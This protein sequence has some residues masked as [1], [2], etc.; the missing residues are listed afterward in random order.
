MADESFLKNFG[1]GGFAGLSGNVG[2]ALTL[3]GAVEDFRSTN[4]GL[5]DKEKK[6]H[7]EHSN[8]LAISSGAF[9]LLTN[10]LAMTD[11]LTD[12]D[13]SKT[14]KIFGGLET[15]MGALYGLANIIGGGAGKAN[16]NGLQKIMG[17]TGGAINILGGLAGI[18]KSIGNFINYKEKG[19]TGKAWK[20][21]I[22]G[23]LGGAGKIF[24]GI[25]GI[26]TA[27]APKSRAWKGWN[28]GAAATGNLIGLVDTAFNVGMA[29][30]PKAAKVTNS[31]PPEQNQDAGPDPTG[32]LGQAAALALT[33]NSDQGEAPTGDLGHTAGRTQ[34]QHQSS[35][36]QPNLSEVVSDYESQSDSFVLPDDYQIAD[37]DG[38]Q[39][40][41][42]DTP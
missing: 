37:L 19:K 9:G 22:M 14:T 21:L 32:D 35:D 34:G 3:S 24:S 27:A 41:H 17:I 38:D 26:G 15:G 6:D 12:E 11:V 23:G 36:A 5:S 7:T 40:K 29:I 20:S 10:G 42:P 8:N 18:G 13:T 1:W 33:D 30:P 28:V 25:T 2:D 31:T 39:P 4:T 16:N